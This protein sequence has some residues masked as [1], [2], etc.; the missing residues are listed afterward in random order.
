M[1]SRKIN[2]SHTYIFSKLVFLVL[3]LSVLVSACGRK[4]ASTSPAVETPRAAENAVNINTA[5]A[6]ELAK[7]PYIGEKSAG[8]IVQHR[9]KYGPFRKP[10]HLMLVE[11]IS[12]KKFRLV[13]TL[14]KVE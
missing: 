12:D 10:E 1:K 14:I 3:T 13:R 9:E 2:N 11:G 6:E 7:I 8:K 5:T 4:P